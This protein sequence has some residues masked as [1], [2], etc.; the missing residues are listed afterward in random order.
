[1]LP[2]V[3]PVVPCMP[4]KEACKSWPVDFV[5]LA[6][7]ITVASSTVELA[8]ALPSFPSLLRIYT[9]SPCE[10][11]SNVV[12]IIDKLDLNGKIFDMFIFKSIKASYY[13]E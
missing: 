6:K 8:T 3:R 1:M 10:I 4:A 7:P 9:A 5:S 12:P 13:Q 11:G 2:G